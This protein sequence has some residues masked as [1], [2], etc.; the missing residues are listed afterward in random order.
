MS[1]GTEKHQIDPVPD[2]GHFP[3]ASHHNLGFQN[4]EEK[5]IGIDDLEE[6]L[7][8]EKYHIDDQKNEEGIMICRFVK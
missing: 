3:D 1:N 7:R 8:K 6:D 2:G 4:D 5:K